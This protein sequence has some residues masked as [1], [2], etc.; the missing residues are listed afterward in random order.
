RTLR[1]GRGLP[2]VL[3]H[4]NATPA[5]CSIVQR[6]SAEFRRRCPP[7]AEFVTR[8]RNDRAHGHHESIPVI[9]RTFGFENSRCAAR[10]VVFLPPLFGG[11]M[12]GADYPIRSQRTGRVRVSAIT[13][14]DSATRS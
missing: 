5:G 11:V 10:P 8:L 6:K 13:A 9:Y 7:R 1:R 14:A 12:L 4:G 2:A 3:P